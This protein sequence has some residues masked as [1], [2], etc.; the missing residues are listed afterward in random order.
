MFCTIEVLEILDTQFL[1]TAGYLLHIS[2]QFFIFQIPIFRT[3][4]TVFGSAVT[5]QFLIFVKHVASPMGRDHE[6]IDL[7]KLGADF[8]LFILNKKCWVVY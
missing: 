4:V 6:E 7:F 1:N 2:R 8:K 3:D 5:G